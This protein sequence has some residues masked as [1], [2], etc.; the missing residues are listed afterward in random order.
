MKKTLLTLALALA[1]GSA[2]AIPLSHLLAGDSITAGDKLFD[3]W[4]L[5]FYDTS[6]VGRTFNAANIDVTP[7]HDGGD[8]PGPGLRFDV[9]NNELSISGDGTYAY[10]DMQFGFRVTALPAGKMIKDNSLRLTGGFLYYM[11]DGDNDLGM[12][13]YETVG[14]SAG[15]ADLGI[16]EVQF[17]L[18]DDALT[19]ENADSASFAPQKSVYVTKNILVWARDDTHPA[20]L[21]Q[22]EQRFSQQVPEPATLG[23]LALGLAGLGLSRLRR[24]A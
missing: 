7:L 6:E 20:A 18:L 9:L 4:Q 2:Q 13:I 10:I 1:A 15:L 12:F 21:W 14:T 16:T 23:L 5:L 8:D 3:Q 24:S 17:S 22:F 19:D 11:P